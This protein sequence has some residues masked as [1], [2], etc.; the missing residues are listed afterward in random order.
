MSQT[1]TPCP[2]CKGDG[3]VL[4]VKRVLESGLV[5]PTDFKLHDLCE[6]CGG[7]GSVPYK[8]PRTIPES[9]VPFAA[10]AYC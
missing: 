3:V 10:G 6:H 8:P 9:V 7:A 1:M 2:A 5:D 4:H